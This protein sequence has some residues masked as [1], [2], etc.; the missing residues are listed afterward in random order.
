[1]GKLTEETECISDASQLSHIRMMKITHLQ[2]TPPANDD[3][4][5]RDRLLNSANEDAPGDTPA[6][7]SQPDAQPL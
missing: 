5:E 4:V 6:A 7:E 2:T 3:T 1:M